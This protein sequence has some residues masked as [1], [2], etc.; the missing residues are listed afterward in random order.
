MYLLCVKYLVF[1]SLYMIPITELLDQDD[2]YYSSDE[3][4]TDRSRKQG[5]EISNMMQNNQVEDL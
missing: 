4:K 1:I 2:N 3:D 5:P